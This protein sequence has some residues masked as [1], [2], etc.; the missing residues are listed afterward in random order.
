MMAD[1]TLS[2][3][4][5]AAEAPGAFARFRTWLGARAEYRRTINELRNLDQRTLDDLGL[6]AA[7]IEA[8]ARGRIVR[9]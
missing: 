4:G 5:H 1:I 2:G 6:N 7:E 3:V 9:R 8:V